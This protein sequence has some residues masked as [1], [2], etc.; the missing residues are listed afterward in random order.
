M[1]MLPRTRLRVRCSGACSCPQSW[2][3]NRHR[4]PPPG[5]PETGAHPAESRLALG[6]LNE[7][8]GHGLWTAVLV[9]NSGC[10]ANADFCHGLEDRGMAYVLQAETEIITHGEKAAPHQPEYSGLSAPARCPATALRPVSLRERS[11]AGGRMPPPA[12][13]DLPQGLESSDEFALRPPVSPPRRAPSGT[14]RRRHDCT[15][16]LIAQWPEGEVPVTYWLSNLPADIPAFWLVSRRS[17][18]GSSMT[19]ES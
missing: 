2:G 14:S 4:D 19:T 5:L 16:L 7:L 9:L 1:S 17:A 3:R 18:G 15:G 8:A 12:D 13:R 6:M 10:D 11:S